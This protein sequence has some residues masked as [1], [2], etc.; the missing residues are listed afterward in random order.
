MFVSAVIVEE[1][2]N[3]AA[4]LDFTRLLSSDLNENNVSLIEQGINHHC[5]SNS[6]SQED[7]VSI[8]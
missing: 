8:V 6:Q 3:S 7:T 5:F 4:L 1:N 2:E